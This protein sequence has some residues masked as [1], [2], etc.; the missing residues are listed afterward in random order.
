MVTREKM[1]SCTSSSPVWM[2]KT[3]VL[4]G[5]DGAGERGKKP[6]EAGDAEMGLCGGR[7]RGVVEKLF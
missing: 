1:R 7:D 3:P 2:E 4:S 5:Q 6:W